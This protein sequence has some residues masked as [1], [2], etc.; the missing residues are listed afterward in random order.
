VTEGTR[1]R[2]SEPSFGDRPSM[3]E[4]V[5][6]RVRDLRKERGWTQDDL[7]EH[8]KLIG[9]KMSRPTV[10]ALESGQRTIDVS[11]LFALGVVLGVAPQLLMYPPPGTSVRIAPDT[12][13][14]HALFPG[15]EV[16]DWLWDPDQ[17]R[18]STAGKG[19]WQIW[20]ESAG[21]ADRMTPEAWRAASRKI[22]DAEG[23]PEVEA[24]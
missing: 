14:R 19:E 2:R 22:R 3:T 7:R 10:V 20:F 11:E 5:A 1:K 13:P 21:M 8:L 15:R 6:G 4:V 23:R 12:H 17:H 18:L 16:A 24:E 9:M